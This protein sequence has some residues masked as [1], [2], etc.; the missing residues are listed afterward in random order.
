VHRNHRAA[1]KQRGF[2]NDSREAKS[3]GTGNQH[4]QL[5]QKQVLPLRD[6]G[7]LKDAEP[8]LN[9][10]L[11]SG[12]TLPEVYRDLADLAEQR[13]AS[14]EADHWRDLW[15]AQPSNRPEPRWQQACASESL[16]R[17]ELALQHFQHVLMLQP[18]HLGALQHSARL[19]LREGLSLRAIALYERWLAEEPESEEAQVCLAAS[20]VDT[21][22]FEQA[23]LALDKPTQPSWQQLDQ[24][25][26]A[27]LLQ[28]ENLEAEALGLAERLLKES[29]TGSDHWMIPR[30]LG[31]LLLEQQQ[32]GRLETAL[33]LAIGEQPKSG[34]LRG[35]EA[36]CFLLQGQI[37]AGYQAFDLQRATQ[38]DRRKR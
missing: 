27:R 38:V 24:A 23:R 10:L 29:E 1:R 30:L 15:L 19:M 12:T 7:R 31:P 21:Q 16:G 4:F 22:L 5:Y 26:R 13:G 20:L 2:G 18:R 36:Q 11:Q 6:V 37:R 35:L 28:N 8:I 17:V 25:V 14:G 33:K 34:R 3:D 9:L 32:L